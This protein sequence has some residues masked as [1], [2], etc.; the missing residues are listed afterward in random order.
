MTTATSK[1]SAPMAFPKYPELPP[2]L[3]LRIIKETLDSFTPRNPYSRAKDGPNMSRY[4]CIDR[5]WNR[6]VELRLFKNIELSQRDG[7]W[8]DGNVPEELVDFGAICGKRSGRLSRVRL[9]IHDA[10]WTTFGRQP[11][12]ETILQLFNLMKDWGHQSREQQGLIELI[13]TFNC[14][15][16][17]TYP[18][19]DGPDD[20]GKFPQVPVIGSIHEPVPRSYSV[21]LH[22]SVSAS[23][24]QK[25]PNIH[26]ASLTLPSAPSED[27]S[28]QNMIGKC[29]SNKS[30]ERFLPMHRQRLALY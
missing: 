28:I 19:L 9:V 8:A 14:T 5:E 13:L 21:H 18:M 25:L 1:S 11:Y 23:L 22:P 10:V 26:H 7:T 15:E 29:T 16:N 3:R 17:W 30:R 6:V 24:Y 20:V 4:A 27:I 2:E 12:L